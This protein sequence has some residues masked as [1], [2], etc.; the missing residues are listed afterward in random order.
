M[1]KNARINI[2]QQQAEGITA[3]KSADLL[4]TLLRAAATR[5]PVHRSGVECGPAAFLEIHGAQ[6]PDGSR[7]LPAASGAVAYQRHNLWVKAIR[8]EVSSGCMINSC[9]AD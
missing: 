7:L 9:K 4:W 5:L 2:R 3:A 8:K 1:G 6:Q